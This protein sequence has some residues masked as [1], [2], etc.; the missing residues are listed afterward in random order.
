MAGKYEGL[1]LKL[2][3]Q[4]QW[5]GPYLFKFIVPVE[6]AD[7]LLRLFPSKDWTKKSSS[8]GN[9]LSFTLYQTMASSDDVI[10]M[11]RK[12]EQIEGLIAL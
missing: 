8:S 10:D 1:K 2:D 3:E 4:F 9:Y 7:A 12:A 6:K 11:Y 5:P